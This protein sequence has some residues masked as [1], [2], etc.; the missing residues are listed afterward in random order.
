MRGRSTGIDMPFGRF[1]WVS[2]FRDGLVVHL[3][4]YMSQSEALEA[5]G[6]SGRPSIRSA[7]LSILIGGLRMSF[8]RS[9][10]TPLSSAR[11]KR[12]NA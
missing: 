4:L 12:R 9:S 11:S 5:A 7:K 3:K 6:L 10:R 8:V 2:T 1:A